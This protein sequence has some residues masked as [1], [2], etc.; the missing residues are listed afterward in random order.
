MI[1]ST[2][3]LADYVQVPG[4]VDDLVDRLL[5][6][7]LNHESTTQV[8]GDTA[9]EIEVTSNRPDCLGHIGVAREAAVLY[10]RPLHV[11]DPRPLEGAGDV[12]QS[13]AVEIR[14]PEICP[15]YTARVVRGVRV[16][17]SPQ[18]LVERLA[19][20][21]VASVN[22]VVDVTNYVMLECGQPLHAFD[23]AGIRGG[24]IVV[25]RAVEGEPFTAINHKVYTLTE[26]MCVIAD[27]ER[28]M[29]LAGVMGGAD[30]EIG[31]GTTDVLIESA[32]F[33]P[34]PVR[35]AARGL[36]LAS[37]SSYRFERGP[38]PAMVD[39]ASRRAAALVLELA[40]G[41]LERG[42]V[43]AGELACAPASIPLPAERVGEVLGM[44]VADTRQ[45]EILTGLGFV[46][47]PAAG[48]QAQRWRAPTWRRDC[49]RD[50][51]LV[52]EIA[53]IE[54]YG[55]VS[56]DAVIAARPIEL[57]LRETTV[58]RAGEVLVGA[59]LCE[60]MTR[61]VVT[62]AFAATASPWGDTPP[63]V[64][65]P[66][67]VR[68]ADRLRRS[69][70]PSLLEARGGNVAVGVNDADIF[71][72]ARAYLA[73]P[74]SSEADSCPVEEPL[75]GSFVVG[76]DFARAKGLADAV[77]AGL[78]IGRDPDTRLDYR[79][80]VLE[81]FARGRGAEI[82]L[83]RRGHAAARIGVV[84]EISKAAAG[85]FGIDAAVAA[86]E[87]RLD[88]LE[89]TASLERPLVKPSDF[90]AMQRD[91][92]L[93][94]DEGVRW[95]DVAAAIRSVAGEVLEDCRLVQVWQDADRLGAGRKSLVVALALRSATGTLSGEEA[96]HVVDAVV[97]ECGRRVNAVLRG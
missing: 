87:L 64:I 93:V 67:L 75:L 33:A 19:T 37:P 58:R 88:R 36:V 10:G 84:G 7:G 21:G 5:M 31:P 86:A 48:P 18:W 17:P 56:E 44:D 15:C 96:G 62:E 43:V 28:P 32:Q 3:W 34:L 54:G 2:N 63:L 40:G 85:R 82:V 35:A 13:I 50:I 92:N 69:L 94:V 57:S 41:L 83:E 53:R 9:I 61:S 25:R 45:R 95:G 29:A 39:W 20:V 76:G 1:I 12:S 60:A 24:R 68:G 80:V 52:E 6:S 79:P 91:I 8:G 97:A 23:L 42:S 22:N 14:S 59:G 11:P 27:A 81:P 49:W 72:V 47:E 89:F 77:L 4:K 90:P 73:R 51:D 30:T 16:G 55:R 26:R 66:P 46:E 71:E 65:A 38:D 78:G 74:V 70:L